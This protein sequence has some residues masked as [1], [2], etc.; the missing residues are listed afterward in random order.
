MDSNLRGDT[1]QDETPQYE[2]PIADQGQGVKH[3]DDAAV[4][5]QEDPDTPTHYD[6]KY[7]SCTTHTLTIRFYYFPFGSKT[8]PTKRIE[9]IT[10]IPIGVLTGKGRIW[11]SSNL[12]RWAN[13]DPGRPWKNEALLIDVGGYIQPVITPDNTASLMAVL[14]RATGLEIQEGDASLL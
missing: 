6:D 8:I 13:L 11:G 3:L 5:G 4:Q 1:R 7:I 2:M 9:Q 12:S 14:R 10:H